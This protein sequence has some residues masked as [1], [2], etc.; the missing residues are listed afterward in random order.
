MIF[1]VVLPYLYLLYLRSHGFIVMLLNYYYLNYLSCGGYFYL[2]SGLS[3]CLFA[4]FLTFF[5]AFYELPSQYYQ[6]GLPFIYIC[7]S[8]FIFFLI[9]IFPLISIYLPPKPYHHQS[10]LFLLLI[11]IHTPLFL[12]S[13][14]QYQ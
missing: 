12:L 5:L 13:Q 1:F 7:L 6:H 11:L 8:I 10:H 2:W 14:Y 3:C 9:F 4:I